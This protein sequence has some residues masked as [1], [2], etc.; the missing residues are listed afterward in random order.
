MIS[1][2][3]IYYFLTADEAIMVKIDILCVGAAAYDL[4]FLTDHHPQEDEKMTAEG[5]F[6]CGGGPAAN[7]AVCA[8]R[9]G[10]ISAFS[11]YIGNDIYGKLHFDEL[12]SDAVLCDWIERGEHPTTFSVSIVK[13]DGKRSLLNYRHKT[14]YLKEGAIDFSNIQPKVVLFDGHEPNLSFELLKL[15]KK[16]DIPTIL[17]AGSLH[18]GTQY[19]MDKVD[20]LISSQ[21]FAEQY[22]QT[23]SM[24]NALNI[25]ASSAPTVVI[26]MGESG[27]I[28]KRCDKKG[29]LESHKVDVVDTTGAGDAFH[30]AFA[31]SLIR[32]M[33]FEDSLQFSNM[34][35]ALTC[36]KVGAR[37]SLPTLKE[38]GSFYKKYGEL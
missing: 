21:T 27:I 7:A 35:A 23:S 5:L 14:P 28:W 1:Q 33:T 3:L 4:T 8:R 20:Y 11:G 29:Y 12:Q 30:G 17:D 19:L 16:Y 31:V 2:P 34:A 26:T 36:T 9:L 37:L 13:R 25:L 32:N 22:S 10:T 24:D 38:V 18:K 15:C 6:S